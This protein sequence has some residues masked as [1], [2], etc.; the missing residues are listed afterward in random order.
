LPALFAPA[1]APLD[2]GAEP[3]LLLPLLLPLLLLPLLLLED[4]VDGSMHWPFSQASE[5]QS[6]NWVHEAPSLSQVAPAPPHTP[7][8]QSLLQHWPF[9][10]HDSPLAEQLG[11]V[12]VPPTQLPLQQSL[13]DSQLSP[14]GVHAT[15]EGDV[16]LGAM[17]TP[18][19]ARLQQSDH[20]AHVT[21]T[22][23][24]DPPAPPSALSH[25]SV[26]GALAQPMKIATRVPRV[27][28]VVRFMA[29][30]F[31]THVPRGGREYSPEIPSVIA[32]QTGRG[33]ALRSHP[34]DP[35]G[36]RWLL[37]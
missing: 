27:I 30:P 8:W 9:D 11:A 36:S 15:P 21:P 1:S 5:Q 32:L 29:G 24:H 13:D 3:E 25:A 20:D 7:P 34:M 35:L 33:A 23:T 26:A 19:Q 31:A 17:Q 28:D 6:P 4:A 37:K 22:A 18:E 10:V 14:A 2:F 12:Q 16:P